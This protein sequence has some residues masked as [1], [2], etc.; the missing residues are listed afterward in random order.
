MENGCAL[1]LDRKGVLSKEG[2][3]N[4]PI[5]FSRFTSFIYY[6]STPFFSLA[7][8]FPIAVEQV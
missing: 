4:Y 6:K 3:L 1:W 2:S 5:I 7:E 8:A